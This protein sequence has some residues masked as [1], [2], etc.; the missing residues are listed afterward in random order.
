MGCD[1]AGTAYTGLMETVNHVTLVRTGG[2]VWSWNYYAYV[3]TAF[4]EL[5]HFPMYFT[6]GET[7]ACSKAVM[8]TRWSCK[9]T[10]ELKNP[11]HLVT[12]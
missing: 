3:L 11:Y 8:C 9:V 4:L 5:N 6:Y 7:E 10:M 1:I 2:G 12:L